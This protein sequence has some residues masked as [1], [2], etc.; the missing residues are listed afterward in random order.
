[1]SEERTDN[2]DEP[3]DAADAQDAA[4]TPIA[5]LAELRHEPAEDLVVGVRRSILRR[6]FARDVAELSWSMPGTVIV[7]FLRMLMRVFAPRGAQ[8]EEDENA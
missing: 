3:G 8:T 7:E 6:V 4:D 5:E 1:M 2:G